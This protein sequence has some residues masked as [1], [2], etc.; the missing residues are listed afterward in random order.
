MFAARSALIAH[1]GSSSPTRLES[2]STVRRAPEATLRSIPALGAALAAV[3]LALTLAAC[4]PITPMPT[5][6]D[7]SA[8]PSLD[9]GDENLPDAIPE[10]VPGGT[11]TQNERFFAYTLEY[12]R[13]NNGIGTADALVGVLINAGFDAAAMEVT[14][15]Y[16]A[17]G[18][19]AD[20]VIVS[21][22][23]GD[24]CLIGQVFADRV[25]STIAAPLGTGRCLVGE[26]HPIG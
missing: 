20:S 16:T 2:A 25:A 21:V 24:E 13:A 5:P 7:S 10:F 12:Y 15:E 23:V 3:A 11:A 18:L 26:T 8:S 6:P 4:G 9:A 1:S 17:I 14:P 19:A 22:R